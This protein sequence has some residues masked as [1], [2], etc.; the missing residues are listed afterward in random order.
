MA[1]GRIAMGLFA[2]LYLYGQILYFQFFAALG[3]T[4]LRES[5]NAFTKE[6]CHIIRS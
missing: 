6:Y 1:F 5:I 4:E 3:N 2:N